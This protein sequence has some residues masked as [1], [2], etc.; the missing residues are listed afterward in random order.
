LNENEKTATGHRGLEEMSKPL[1]ALIKK[2]LAAIGPPKYGISWFVSTPIVARY[3]LGDNLIKF[4]ARYCKKS[5]SNQTSGHV[6]F[7]LQINCDS[8]SLVQP[9]SIRI[10][11][12]SVAG[13]IMIQEAS[14]FQ[15]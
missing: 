4:F 6:E 7:V 5:A 2:A 13:R 11:W 8:A 9:N 1:T 15:T 10:C 12:S 14:L 3:R